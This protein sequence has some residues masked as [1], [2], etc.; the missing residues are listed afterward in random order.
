[1]SLITYD[2]FGSKTDKVKRS[3]ERIRAF[4]PE[5]GYYNTDSFGKDSTVLHALMCM[6]GVKFDTHYNVTTVDPPE[7]VRFGISQFDTVIYD[8]PDGTHKYYTTH[9]PGKLLWPI[10]QSAVY[11]KVIHF[12]IP[13][14]PM[15][16]LIV[17]KKFPPTRLQR[18][19]CE[20]LKEVNG[21]GRIA[22]TG[23]RWAESRNRKDNQGLVTIFFDESVMRT[24]EEQGANITKTVRGGGLFLILIMTRS[25]AR[26][27]SATARI[28]R[29]SIRSSTGRTRMFGNFCGFTISHTVPFMTRAPSAWAA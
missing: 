26:L 6:A 1:M 23:V 11:G 7:L 17:K 27:K 12:S 9:H 18:Y 28:R 4:E 19:C 15:R 13:E 5:E 16:K 8:M 29:W 2:L 21:M 24:A 20:A 14:L 22:T 10:P 3:I 25:A